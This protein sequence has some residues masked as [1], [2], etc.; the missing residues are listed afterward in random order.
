MPFTADAIAAQQV[1]DH[2]KT[3][4]QLV[5]DIEK[6]RHQSEQ[7]INNITK[8]QSGQDEKNTQHHQMKLKSLY[9]T[10]ISQADQEEDVI[11]KAL[12][13]I[14]EIRN[15]KNERRIQV[16]PLLMH[17]FYFILKLNL[18]QGTRVI[19]NRSEGVLG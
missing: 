7:G 10:A 3:L 12:Q 14:T 19:K 9:K 4:Y 2:L 18:R 1:Q 16:G 5:H 11:R 13:R 8:F 6:K 17:K 15:I